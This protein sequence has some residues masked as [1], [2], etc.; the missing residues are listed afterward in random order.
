M[1][2]GLRNSSSTHLSWAP[3]SKNTTEADTVLA[4]RKAG[5]LP[6]TSTG[7][8]SI[9]LEL[10]HNFLAQILGNPLEQ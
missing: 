5:C 2:A 7:T 4:G 8:G 3:W 9:R 6:G 10:Q 1:R